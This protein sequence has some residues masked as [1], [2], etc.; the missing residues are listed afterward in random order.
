MLD[1]QVANKENVLLVIE[2]KTRKLASQLIKIPIVSMTN[3]WTNEALE[4]E[5]DVVEKRHMF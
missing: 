2:S 1:L 5:M 3:M 4:I